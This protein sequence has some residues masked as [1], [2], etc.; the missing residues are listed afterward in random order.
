MTNQK[1]VIRVNYVA[2]S[3]Y[4][5]VSLRFFVCGCATGVRGGIDSRAIRSRGV[6]IFP[7]AALSFQVR[8]L[9]CQE[10]TPMLLFLRIT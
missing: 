9:Q 6:W 4:F 5:G 1:I 8:Y 10:M 7:V 3:A 2:V